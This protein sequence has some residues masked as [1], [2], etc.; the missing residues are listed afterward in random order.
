MLDSWE[1]VLGDNKALLMRLLTPGL[2]RPIGRSVVGGAHVYARREF[3]LQFAGVRY[4]EKVGKMC[5][6]RGGSLNSLDGLSGGIYTVAS[7]VVSHR[8][9]ERLLQAS[10][11]LTLLYPNPLSKR[12]PFDGVG[13]AP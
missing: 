6:C 13:S 2:A 8:I 9:G 1:L 4:D 5:D 7:G 12:L 3:P 10:F 11:R